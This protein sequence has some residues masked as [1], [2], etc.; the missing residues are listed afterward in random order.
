MGAEI[1]L[2]CEM[3]MDVVDSCEY[4]LNENKHR[5][6]NSVVVSMHARITSEYFCLKYGNYL[7]MSIYKFTNLRMADH[8]VFCSCL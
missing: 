6:A 2:I 7:L 8:V 4:E 5:A 3:M 1:I